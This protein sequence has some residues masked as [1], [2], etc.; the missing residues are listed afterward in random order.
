MDGRLLDEFIVPSGIEDY[1]GWLEIL[2]AHDPVFADIT[3]DGALEA[4]MVIFCARAHTVYLRRSQKTRS[5]GQGRS[6][7][8]TSS[9]LR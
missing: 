6:W 3:G 7:W 9:C 5:P 1:R 2:G 8:G 4:I